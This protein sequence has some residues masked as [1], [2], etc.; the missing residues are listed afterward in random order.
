MNPA[1]FLYLWWPEGWVHI[2]KTG[3]T[4]IWIVAPYYEL[5]DLLKNKGYK[6]NKNWTSVGVRW[7]LNT[8]VWRMVRKAKDM[9]YNSE[10]YT[11]NSMDLLEFL[12]KTMPSN[13]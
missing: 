4:E 1:R 11:S 3:M 6:V 7:E 8:D 5:I 12:N 2:H 10:Y 13:R 9:Y